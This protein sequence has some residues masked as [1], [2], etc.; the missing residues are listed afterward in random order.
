MPGG[1]C[2]VGV[3]CP[4]DNQGRPS[5]RSKNELAAH[6][7][8]TEP[9]APSRGSYE[10]VAGR[11]LDEYQLV[12]REIEPGPE[13]AGPLDAGPESARLRLEK[14]HR[15][16]QGE[17]KAIFIDMGHVL[18][19]LL[20]VVLLSGCAALN[21]LLRPGGPTLADAMWK[22]AKIGEPTSIASTI[23]PRAGAA[24]AILHGLGASAQDQLGTV[25]PVAVLGSEEIR[26]VLCREKYV[27]KCAQIPLH[28]EVNFTGSLIAG[29]LW[30]P[31]A[32]T[33]KN[34]D[35]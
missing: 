2:I 31:S 22:G 15:H 33:A 16:I 19:V 3:C 11:I 21:T 1:C 8:E 6:L 23:D 32:L 9:E 4:P 10:D 28:T 14:L 18:P 25:M 27:E 30:Y 13:V 35:D 24:A 5:S 29:N 17:L 12:P 7:A 34:F 20:C 26:L